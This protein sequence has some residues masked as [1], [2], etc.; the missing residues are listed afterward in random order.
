M[1]KRNLR[2]NIWLNEEEYK[3]LKKKSNLCGMNESNYL[4]SLI[5]DYTPKESPSKEFFA[6]LEELRKIN[7]KFSIILQRSLEIGYLTENEFNF[8]INTIDNLVMDLKKKY[9]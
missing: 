6:I 8:S 4:R 9:L 2:K 5:L 1:R 3:K 7:T